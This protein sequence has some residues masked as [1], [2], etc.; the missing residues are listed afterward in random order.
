[1]YKANR[2]REKQQ[3]GFADYGEYLESL[4]MKGTV[5][6]FEPVY[7]ARIAQLTNKFVR[8]PF[9]IPLPDNPSWHIPYPASTPGSS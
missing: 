9:G 7:M 6:P 2:M 4:E 1:M 3:A 5:R 8:L